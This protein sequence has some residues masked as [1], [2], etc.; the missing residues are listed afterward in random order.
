MNQYQSKTMEKVIRM[1]RRDGVDVGFNSSNLEPLNRVGCVGKS[2][3][4]KTYTLEQVIQLAYEI[5]ANIIV[6]AGENAKWYLKRC[7]PTEIDA[8]IEKQQRWRNG[9][10]RYKMWIIEWEN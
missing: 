2:G 9:T 3:I 10:K 8:K 5:R 4:D 1:E 6:K 7:D